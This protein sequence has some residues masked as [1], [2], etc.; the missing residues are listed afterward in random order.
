MHDYEKADAEIAMGGAVEPNHPMLRA[1]RATLNFYRGEVD[2]AMSEIREVLAQ[3]P[4]LHS[5]KITLAYCHVAKGETD[6][7]L[8][9]LD[10]EVVGSA[11]ADQDTAYRLGTLYAMAG[12]SDEAIEWL[13]RAVAMGNENYPWISTNPYWAR[14]RGDRRFD[15]I[16]QSLRQKWER[17]NSR[18]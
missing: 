12:K 7:A 2:E 16:V 8:A 10:D 1:Y 13:E 18:S 9:L 4:D 5:Q 17:L 3:H 15:D 6:V 14:L 11:C